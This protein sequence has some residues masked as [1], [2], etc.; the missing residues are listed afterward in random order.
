[1]T[2][3]IVGLGCIL[4]WRPT[5]EVVGQGCRVAGGGGNILEGFVLGC[6]GDNRG[7]RTRVGVALSAWET[8]NR[9]FLGVDRK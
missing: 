4:F 1:M 9:V 8:L 2:S 6:R 3:E 5:I 7:Y